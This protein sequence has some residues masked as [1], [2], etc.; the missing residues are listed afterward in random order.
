M[1]PSLYLPR[2]LP[3]RLKDLDELALDLRWTWDRT[4][5][6]LWQAIDPAMW[7]ASGNPW[8]ILES[9]PQRRLEELA[10]DRWFCQ[11]LAERLKAHRE[12]PD[13]ETWFSRNSDAGALGKVAYFSMEFGLSEAIPIYAGSSGILAGDT[14]K[15]ASDL[16]VPLVGIGLLYQQ[17]H[18][19]QALDPQGN[20]L[21]SIPYNEPCMLPMSPVRDESGE[22]LGITVDLPGREVALRA[23]QVQVGRVRLYLLDSNDPQNHPR[24]RAI[25]AELYGGDLEN[26]LKQEIILGIGGWR[27]LRALNIDAAICHLHDAQGAFAVLERAR[28]F[29]S[30]TGLQFAQSL[31][32][33]RAGNIYT[34]HNTD[35]DALVRF[36]P[37]LIDRYFRRYCPQMGIVPA[38]ILALGRSHPADSNEPLT[39][40]YLAVRGSGKAT[41]GNRSQGDAGRR[42]LEPLFPRWPAHE[43][44]LE[45]VTHGIH[46]P[47]WESAAAREL[48]TISCGRTRW[49]D[50]LD[51]IG[52]SISRVGDEALWAFRNMGRTELT[53]V[54]QRRIAR[55]AAFGTAETAGT[56]F[57]SK[58]DPSILTVGV[59]FH[60]SKCNR[61]DLLLHDQDRWT[62]LLTHPFSPVQLVLAGKADPADEE[63]KSLVREWAQYAKRP[64]VCRRIVFVEDYD[65][66]LA[67][68]LAHG[69]DLWLGSPHKLHGRNGISGM[70]LMVNGGLNLSGLDGWWGDAF[71]TE[72]GWAWRDE[73]TGAINQRL[74][75]AAQNQ[76]FDLLETE[77]IPA[78]YDRD[79]RGI[80]VAWV[81]RMRESMA[82]LTPR[83]S[84]NRM[85]R[86]FTELCYLPGAR[87]CMRRSADKGALGTELAGWQQEISSYWSGLHFGDLR[88]ETAKGGYT[89]IV[90]LHLGSLRADTVRVELYADPLECKPAVCVEMARGYE[91]AGTPHTHLYTATVPA[92]RPSGDYTPRVIP[93]HPEA[94]V[95]MEE[96]HALWQ[97]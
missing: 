90:Q 12:Y 57:V 32:C 48:W 2:P 92:D 71:P 25:T 29:M 59:V 66:T 95:P 76:I 13:Q 94:S 50:T 23:W 8:L 73:E 36:P 22:W 91:V 20:Q 5:D 58:L 18:F 46:V 61:A 51:G 9:A 17:G 16:G 75:E 96:S 21:E 40:A 97:H 69:V 11:E 63:G 10:D 77:V 53:E 89:F 65:I 44:P 4:A 34:A 55:Q 86:E 82:H 14:L 31:F 54:L 43:V 74:S 39:L 78:F 47:S 33:T 3:E 93:M 37:E 1:H 72:A 81:S 68:R 70:K 84:A 41:A 30:D 45:H 49:H 28:C 26:R 62:R 83:F 87:A 60:F 19:R 56:R 85:L 6:V 15:S 35:K 38:D 67:Q 42:L 27:L 79:S 80:P 7:E 64:D 52:Q 88:V 24:D